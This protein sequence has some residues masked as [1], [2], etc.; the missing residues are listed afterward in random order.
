MYRAVTLHGIRRG[1][2]RDGRVDERALEDMLPEIEIAFE[3]NPVRGASDI[4]L[5]GENVEEEIRGVDVSDHVSLVGRIGAVRRRLVGM[6][7]RM[8]TDK[9]IVMDGRDI[10][11]VV[12]PDAELKIFMTADPEVRALRRYRELEA[13][14]E[15][16]SLDEIRDNLDRRDRSDRTREIGPLRQ[17]KDAVVL[18]NSHM[19]L[20]EELQWAETLIDERIG[21]SCESK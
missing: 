15:R 1:A 13:K 2:I 17:A 10:G 16:V 7:Q 3:F 18:D 19:T 5:N 21:W 12:F 4:Y 8:G 14:G 6:Q 11:T 20:E 9:G